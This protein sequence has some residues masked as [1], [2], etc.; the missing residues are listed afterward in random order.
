MFDFIGFYESSLNTFKSYK[1][2]SG[3]IV[4][5][6]NSPGQKYFVI[7]KTSPHLI[8]LK[9]ILDQ[10]DEKVLGDPSV[11]QTHLHRLASSE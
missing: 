1:E 7:I 5:Y 3:M 11:S 2:K 8:N 4:H 9:N 10:F 6:G